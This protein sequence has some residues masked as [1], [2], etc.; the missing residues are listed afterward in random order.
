[1]SVIDQRQGC[2]LL[3]R[4]NQDDDRVANSIELAMRLWL[5][6]GFGTTPDPGVSRHTWDPNKSID[7]ALITFFP[8][9]AE[10]ETYDINIDNGQYN[11]RYTGTFIR[12][13]DPPEPDY[14]REFSS[15]FT[16]Y[17]MCRLVGFEI[18]W[19][20]N[21]L[22]HL[23]VRKYNNRRFNTT[24]YIFHQASVLDN[25]VHGYVHRV[26]HMESAH[27]NTGI[28]SHELKLPKKHYKLSAS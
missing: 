2:I 22:N 25:L 21:L 19:T 6:V 13:N 16:L 7:Q 3:T 28:S 12:R 4:S 8:L 5:M 11:G 23:L 1:M 20:N 17:D 10:P 26:I 27:C 24:V 9:A 14:D 15:L 18:I